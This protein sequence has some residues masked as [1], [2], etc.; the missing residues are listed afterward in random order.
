MPVRYSHALPDRI[1]R[2]PK[3]VIKLFVIKIKHIAVR[4]VKRALINAITASV[5]TVMHVPASVAV[6]INVCQ[7][8]VND[9]QLARC[10]HIKQI[11]VAERDNIAHERIYRCRYKRCVPFV[12]NSCRFPDVDTV[13][14]EGNGVVVDNTAVGFNNTAL[15]SVKVVNRK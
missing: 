6:I 10:L 5:K 11:Y 15:A 14:R 12:F 1:D 8:F 4:E 7:P 3:V 13:V 9:K 2:V